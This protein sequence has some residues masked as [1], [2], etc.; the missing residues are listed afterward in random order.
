MKYAAWTA[1]IVASIA[2]A[3]PAAAGA[4]NFSLLPTPFVHPHFS[5]GLSPP[6]RETCDFP[7]PCWDKL[8]QTPVVV[9]APARRVVRRSK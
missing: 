7:Q 3:G 8:Q 6:G 1:V 9:V 2:V 5:N 4:D